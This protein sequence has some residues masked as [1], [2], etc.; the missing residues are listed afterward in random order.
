MLQ[1]YFR[2]L[3]NWNRTFPKWKWK[4]QFKSDSTFFLINWPTWTQYRRHYYLF[5]IHNVLKYIFFFLPIA[6]GQRTGIIPRDGSSYICICILSTPH[7]K[8]SI[9]HQYIIFY[10][11]FGLLVFILFIIYYSVDSFYLLF[12]FGISF[13]F[14]SF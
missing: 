6:C 5:N 9:H 11:S 14:I 8:K 10:T 3:R 2:Y 7:Q 12:Y 13:K 1:K 4:V